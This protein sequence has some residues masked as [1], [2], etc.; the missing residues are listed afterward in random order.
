M[1]KKTN[2][3]DALMNS[4]MEEIEEAQPSRPKGKF[5]AD[6]RYILKINRAGLQSGK[7]FTGWTVDAEVIDTT[8][9][10][11]PLKA[12]RPGD[13]AAIMLKQN[14]S[15]PG[16]L[17]AIEQNLAVDRRALLDGS[18][19]VGK[20]VRVTATDSKLKDGSPF[21]F[22]TF[23]GFAEEGECL[24]KPARP[25]PVSEPADDEPPF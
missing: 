23:T 19:L 18:A 10:P 9:A 7:K 8:A 4:L 16:N 1:A 14:D 3:E 20:L 24:S 17:K 22:I 21:T 2:P 25:A 13:S 11:D 15:L 5:L 6:G 12:T